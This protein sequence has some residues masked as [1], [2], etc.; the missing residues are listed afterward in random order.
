MP[1]FIT[2]VQ[3]ASLINDDDVVVFA[4]E[5]LSNFP[6]EIVSAVEQRFLKEGHPRNITSMRAAGMGNFKDQG[7]HLWCH[8]GLLT[9]SISSYLAVC[10]KLAG[11]VE[12][13][14]VQAY[15]FPM[16]AI[17]QMYMAV[18]RGL[19][20]ALTR[21]G[22]GTFMDARQD[23]GKCNQL[24]IDEGEDLVQYIP[25]LMGE[26]YLFY[27]SPGMNVALLRGTYADKNGNI[28]CENEI[29]DMELMAVA[30]AVKASGGIVI[31]QVEKIVEV[32][33]I[34]ARLV[35]LPGIYVDYVV[36]AENRHEIP[37][38]GGRLTYDK[39]NKGFI[40]KKVV[41]I[42]QDD[43]RLPLDHKKVIARR[44]AMEIRRGDS[45]NFGIGM[46]QNIPSIL[47]ECGR[48]GDITMI[49]ET[50]VIGGV[51]GVDRDFG[52]HW[53]PE[54]FSDHGMHFS[55]FDGGMLDVGVFGI[56]EVDASGD[57]NTSHLNGRITGIGG[58]TN[59][60]IG[61]KKVLFVGTFTAGGL[62]TRVGDGKLTILQEGKFKKFIDKCA[63]VSF[64]GAERVRERGDFL[65]ITERCVLRYTS[66]G[67]ILEEVAPGIDVRTQI[68]EQC[69][70]PLILPEGGPKRMDPS[71]FTEDGFT[72]EH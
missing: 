7:E 45:V 37:Q 31:V 54:A 43:I 36:L 39:Y 6:N 52:C 48:E 66:E 16:G 3:A 71:L 23:G 38:N 2:A 65:L 60:T 32:Y 67:M 44:A 26:D 25:D 1:K 63:K 50:G 57:M 59:I 18:G 68:I 17:L 70:I 10:P 47:T 51:P 5:G 34:L 13:N 64:C 33:G 8:E 11:L 20:G 72:L 69:D 14:K 21:V 4:P 19:P 28:S 15:M 49:S 61:A 22:L 35:K 41:E 42:Q 56:G 30:Q 29:S 53:N 27:K 46:P 9:R 62:K 55:Y 58:F 24:T 40:G 12:E